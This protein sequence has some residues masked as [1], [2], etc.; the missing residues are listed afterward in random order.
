MDAF[1]KGWY[2]ELSPDDT[3]WPGQ[4]MSLQVEEVLLDERSEYQHIQVLRTATSRV[5][6]SPSTRSCSQAAARSHPRWAA[7]HG[8]VLG[9]KTAAVTAHGA[10]SMAK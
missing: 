3:M 4:A 5:R 10:E 8:G 7:A 2:T 6:A 9:T 1:Q